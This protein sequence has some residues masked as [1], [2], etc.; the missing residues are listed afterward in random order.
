[1]FKLHSQQNKIPHNTTKVYT[2]WSEVDK[3]SLRAVYL[4]IRLLKNLQLSLMMMQSRSWLSDRDMVRY[5]WFMANSL[6]A[7]CSSLTSAFRVLRA[8][9]S[10]QSRDLMFRQMALSA[11][12]KQLL[13]KASSSQRACSIKTITTDSFWQSVS[14]MSVN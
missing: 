7:Q 3:K 11:G 14:K 1:M 6:L 5:R 9:E 2:A 4:R 12:K 8:F 10:T 13:S